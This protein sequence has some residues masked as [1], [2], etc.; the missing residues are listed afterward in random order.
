ML[1][2]AGLVSAR[3]SPRFAAA[4]P[5]STYLVYL[6]ERSAKAQCLLNKNHFIISLAWFRLKQLVYTL[7]LS[8]C[9]FVV[10]GLSAS[11]MYYMYTPSAS[12]PDASLQI[13][14]LG[15]TCFEVTW[16]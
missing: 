8:I 2:G 9:N 11:V 6:L 1:V 16:V 10:R 15:Y 4:V 7:R 5:I 3:E 14:I 12:P 13:E